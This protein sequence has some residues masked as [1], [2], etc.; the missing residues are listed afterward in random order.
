MKLKIMKDK[1]EECNGTRYCGIMDPMGVCRIARTN[2]W[3][4]QNLAQW[5]YRTKCCLTEVDEDWYCAKKNW[6]SVFLCSLYSCVSFFVVVLNPIITLPS[7][8]VPCLFV[9]VYRVGAS[10]TLI[11]SLLSPLIMVVGFF[12]P[13]QQGYY[14]NIED[15]DNSNNYYYYYYLYYNCNY[16]FYHW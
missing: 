5:Q 12:E 15:D 3:Y 2:S 13:S 7:S 6:G 9:G 14:N 8:S 4:Y 10:Q 1:G 11:P 16:Y